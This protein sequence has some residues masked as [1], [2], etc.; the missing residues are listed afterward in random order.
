MYSICIE[1]VTTVTYFDTLS[2]SEKVTEFVILQT[3]AN[4][5]TNKSLKMRKTRKSVTKLV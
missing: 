1:Y 4:T 2:C 5:V 3:T